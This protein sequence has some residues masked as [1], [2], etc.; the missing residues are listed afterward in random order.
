MATTQTGSRSSLPWE[1]LTTTIGGDLLL[2]DHARYEETRR[3]WNAMIDRRP[4]AIVRPRTVDDVAA[5]VR[6]AREQGLEIAVRGGGH[7]AAGLA[8]VDDGLVIDLAEMNQ[9]DVD[10]ERRVARA[11]GGATWGDF[12]AATQAHGLASTGGAISMT[13]IGGLTLGGGLGFLMRSRGLACDNLIGAQVVL[14]DG[15]VVQTSETERPELLWGLRG[16]GGNFGVVTEFVYRLQPLDGMY[17]GLLIYP[18]E[19]ASDA[20]RTF[21]EQTTAA[22]DELTTFIAMLNTPDGIPVVAY[23]PA[24]AGD[25][26]AGEAAVAGYRALGAPVADL[27]GPMP[28]V[29][30]QRMLDDGFQPGAH[31]YWRSHF[32]TGLPDEAIAIMVDGANSAPSPLNNVLVEHLG[33]AVAR[34]GKD[35]TAFDHR[36]A[37]YNFA[38]IAV[39]NDP[40]E[41]E[42]NIAWARGLWEA[43][44]PF[45]RGA[46]VN[47]LGV[48]D[49][50]ERVRAAYGPEKYA[51]LAALKREY[52]PENLFHRNQNILPGYDSEPRPGV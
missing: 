15:S 23:I 34:V 29:A 6:F 33:G 19:R 22:P 27:V 9:V 44:E 31:V 40:A 26:A 1:T 41:A 32:L 50:A 3:V 25:A 7:N 43:L 30:L 39:W 37:E 10:P 46:Y 52:D 38:V 48:G 36:D 47:Y 21:R 20:L 51:R 28:Y 14:A 45:S 16:G 5:A 17:A 12:D 18:R 11:G 24:Y 13:G 8:V 2:P 35:E 49:S 4:A 42:A